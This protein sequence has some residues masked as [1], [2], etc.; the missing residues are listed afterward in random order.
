MEFLVSI[1]ID[2][3]YDFPTSDFEQ[4]LKQERSRG[5]ELKKQGSIVR[6]W[7]VPGS[8]NNVGIWSALDA[9]QLHALLNSLPLFR[10]MKID[11]VSLAVHPLE[12]EIE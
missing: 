12:E 7:R 1:N 4:L 3:P 9:T 10:F 11:V 6:I 8:R 2:V 5:Q